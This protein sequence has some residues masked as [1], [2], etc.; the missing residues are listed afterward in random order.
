VLLVVEREA[1]TVGKKYYARSAS[2]DVQTGGVLGH[3]YIRFPNRQLCEAFVQDRIDHG[4]VADVC[5]STPNPGA[6]IFESDDDGLIHPTK[7]QRIR[8]GSCDVV[9]KFTNEY[10]YVEGTQ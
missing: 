1:G 4:G 9:I 10:W 7:W 5:E 3:T 6:V 2:L 8:F